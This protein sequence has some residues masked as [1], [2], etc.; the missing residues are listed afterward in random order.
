[1][2]T[3]TITA[4]FSDTDAMGHVNNARFFSFMEEARVAFFSGL[5]PDIKPAEA[6][7]MFPFILADIQCSFKA[8]IFCGDKI[9][10]SVNVTEIGTKSFTMTYEL[11]NTATKQVVATGKS[12][13]VMFDYKTGKSIPVPQAFREKLNISHA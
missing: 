11:K 6:F 12:I 1:M 13:Q 3:T 7:A 8:P 4:R 9:D 10:V 2:T 5:F